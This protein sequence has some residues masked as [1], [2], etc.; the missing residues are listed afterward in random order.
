MAVQQRFFAFSSPLTQRLG[1]QAKVLRIETDEKV[2]P[3]CSLCYDQRMDQ[4]APVALN[5]SCRMNGIH[6]GRERTV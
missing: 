5:R 1:T 4:L 6:V 2:H 3:E